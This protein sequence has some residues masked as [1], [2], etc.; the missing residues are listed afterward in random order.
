MVIF[1][2]EN[3]R[4]SDFI[5]LNKKFRNKHTYIA[6]WFIRKYGT[7]PTCKKAVEFHERLCKF[8]LDKYGKLPNSYNHLSNVNHLFKSNFDHY[9]IEKLKKLYEQIESEFPEPFR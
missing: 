5:K 1:N 3:K 7:Y 9:P 4:K 2:K 8:F 6:D